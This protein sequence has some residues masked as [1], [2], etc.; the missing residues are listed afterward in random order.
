MLEA[1][2]VTK[3]FGAKRAP[4]DVSLRVDGGVVTDR[5]VMSISEIRS[6]CGQFD[7]D[8]PLMRSERPVM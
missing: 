6:A 2:R 1:V 5:G 7:G 8:W 4:N 3:A